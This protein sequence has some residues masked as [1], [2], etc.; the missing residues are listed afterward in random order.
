MTRVLL[1]GGT[2]FLGQSVRMVLEAD[3][4]DV[5]TV[6]RS[7]TADVR[8]DATD[9]ALV[10]PLLDH[11][12]DVVVNL[13]GAGLAA[14][15]ADPETMSS[16]NALFPA[17]LYT[18][19]AEHR[20]Q[21]LFVHAASS[22]ERLPDQTADESEYSRTKH[23]GS[24]RLRAS[25]RAGGPDVRVLTIHNTYGPGQPGARFVAATIDRLRSGEGIALA[26][27]DRIRDF[28]LVSDVAA[29]IAAAAQG[30][31][32]VEQQ[33]G[34]GIGTSLRDA[35]LTIAD[36]LGRPASLV[37]TGTAPL[38]DPNPVTVS[39]VVGGTLGL[40][41]TGFRDGIRRTLREH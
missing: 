16:V 2:G 19:L 11:D 20:P 41:T 35:A 10:T 32:P 21:C 39:P 36:E 40:C 38:E 25:L 30:W 22:T 27:P 33:V 37:T 15:S 13:L 34:T 26:Y 31:G 29:S 28:V 18:L 23:E 14:G 12:P 6:A 8:I 7:S 5:T 24:Q 4:A 3:G 17:A 1:L 9:P